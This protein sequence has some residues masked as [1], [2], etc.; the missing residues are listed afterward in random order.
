MIDQV[1]D[2]V[3]D[4]TPSDDETELPISK[5]HNVSQTIGT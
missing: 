2:P 5:Y 1:R 4:L 3:Q